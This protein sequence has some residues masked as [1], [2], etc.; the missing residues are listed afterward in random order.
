MQSHSEPIAPFAPLDDPSSLLTASAHRVPVIH[1]LDGVLLG[2]QYLWGK[3]QVVSNLVH[4]QSRSPQFA[5]ELAV[6]SQCLLSDIIAADGFP[7]TIL[8]GGSSGSPWRG[9]HALMRHLR[10]KPTA[11]LHTHGFKA[12]VVGRLARALGAPMTGIV[13]TSHGF[14]NSATRLHFYNAIDRLSSPASDVV[15]MP[16]ET[17]L[18]AF[19]RAANAKFIPNAI[20]D[21]PLPRVDERAR[22]RQRFGWTEC[23]FV[24]GAMGRLSAEKGIPE[25]IEAALSTGAPLRWAVAGVGPLQADIERC[26]PSR[27]QAVGYVS[28]SD[29]YVT[30]IDV[31]VQSSRGEGLSLSLLQAM[32]AAKP[33]VATRVNATELAIRDGVDGLL[34][35]PLSASAL[36]EGVERVQADRSLAQRLGASARARFLE[37][38]RIERQ[39]EAYNDL[40]TRVC[41]AHAISETRSV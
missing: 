5:P 39:A 40:Y 13:S 16:D 38:F 29:D 33:I 26:D 15:T 19:P 35:E 12:N 11:I 27:I 41:E 10:T 14:D 7:V 6:F 2:K 31:Y 30:A 20:P 36:A 37:K 18:G 9:L 17:M 23:D 1:V 22:A 28:P 3:E 34:V 4:A 32:R 21:Q 25:F 24:A 8:N